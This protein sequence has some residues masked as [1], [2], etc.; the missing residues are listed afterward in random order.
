MKQILR[1]LLTI[2]LLTSFS[3]QAGNCNMCCDC[4]TDCDL[5]CLGPCDGY[6]FLLPRSQG[7]NAA[8]DLIGWQQFINQYEMED[9]YGSFAITFEYN[10]SM[11]PERITQFYF[12]D[13]LA[14]CNGLLMHT[15]R[16]LY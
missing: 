8:R 4:D 16:Q 13:Q 5:C 9:T 2:L 15:P 7:R 10:R 11:R 14:T 6:P 3:I 12:G 1:G